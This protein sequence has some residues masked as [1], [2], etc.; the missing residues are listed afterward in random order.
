VYSRFIHAR[1]VG[2]RLVLHQLDLAHDAARDE[3]DSA[4]DSSIGVPSIV[5]WVTAQAHAEH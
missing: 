4:P 1:P 2:E 5:R 3:P